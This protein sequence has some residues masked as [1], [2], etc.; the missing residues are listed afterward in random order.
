MQTP[1]EHEDY[2]GTGFNSGEA[3]PDGK[4]L[5]NNNNTSVFSTNSAYMYICE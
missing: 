3:T 1:S 2:D 4:T 5:L